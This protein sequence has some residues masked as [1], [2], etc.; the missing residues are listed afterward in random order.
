MTNK[1][2]TNITD[3]YGTIC[4]EFTYDIAEVL[5]QI[6]FDTNDKG[7][8]QDAEEIYQILE[9]NKGLDSLR[10]THYGTSI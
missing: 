8:I 10:R 7:F 3:N 1:F 9:M 6:L 4:Y 2:E 5:F